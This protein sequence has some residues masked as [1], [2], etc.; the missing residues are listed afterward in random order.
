V[1]GWERLV[2]GAAALLLAGIT[3]LSG[4]AAPVAAPDPGAPGGRLPTVL[5]WA[6]ED[7]Q[8]PI[9][10]V[11]DAEAEPADVDVTVVDEGDAEP[12]DEGAPPAAPQL[13]TDDVPAADVPLD[14]TG[15]PDPELLDQGAPPPAQPVP[16][17]TVAPAPAPAPVPVDTTASPAP[18]VYAAPAATGPVLPE[19]FGTG[20]VHVSA[21]SAGFPEGLAS[22]HVGAV[23]GRAYVGIDCDE[24]GDTF[25]GHA[26]S[27]DEFPFVVEAPFPFDD[28]DGLDF[29]PEPAAED[30]ASDIFVSATTAPRDLALDDDPTTPE[31][32]AT[33]NASVSFEQRARDREPRVRASDR[34]ASRANSDKKGGQE[35]ANA[36]SGDAS[37]DDVAAE[38]RQ[39]ANDGKSKDKD[40]D[41]KAKAD[42]KDKDK[43]KKKGK[44]KKR[45]RDKKERKR[46]QD[47]R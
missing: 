33:G 12:L 17:E 7:A 8:P 45:D 21:G 5:A 31:V 39:S 11:D 37:S 1:N 10:P 35:R 24:G 28:A 34:D 29:A 9:E 4:I 25:V 30:T 47:E 15:Q 46:S 32:A 16:V 40:K 22:C 18:A 43:N 23:T 14:P 36:Q 3:W 19:G 20:R 44:N 6:Q 13:V 27:F 41:K 26:P 2:E 38:S 42:K